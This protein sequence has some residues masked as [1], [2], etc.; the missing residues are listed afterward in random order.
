LRVRH[1]DVKHFFLLIKGSQI[2]SL[3]FLT[4]YKIVEKGL[5]DRKTEETIL[6]IKSFRLRQAC[7]LDE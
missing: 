3:N 1:I 2:T 5:D 6:Y 7:S 4:Q